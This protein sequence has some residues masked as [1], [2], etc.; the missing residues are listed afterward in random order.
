MRG[1]SH[2]TAQAEPLPI[3]EVE[4]AKR[5]SDRIRNIAGAFNRKSWELDDAL[6]NLRNAQLE[7]A[8][9][10]RELALLTADVLKA[11]REAELFI[12]HNYR[13]A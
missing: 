8:P 4:V 12:V 2:L 6:T 1:I 13:G 5:T 7:R 11:Y 9:D 10:P 3:F